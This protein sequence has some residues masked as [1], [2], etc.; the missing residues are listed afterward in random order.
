MP[1]DL[2]NRIDFPKYQRWVDRMAGGDCTLKIFNAAGKP[3]RGRR[4]PA[5]GELARRLLEAPER[6]RAGVHRLEFE[7]GQMLLYRPLHMGNAGFAGWA[8]II[9][10]ERAAPAAPLDLDR[11]G[12]ALDDVV[13]GVVGEAASNYELDRMAEE[14]AECYEDLSLVFGMEARVTAHAWDDQNVLRALLQSTAEH[15]RADVAAFVRPA[16]G[17]CV[18]ATSLS[19]EMQNL[20]LVLIEMRG[21]LFRFVQAAKETV[22]VNEANDPHRPDI[23][24][25]M[26]YRVLASP[27]K[28]EHS[29]EGIVVLLNHVHKRPFSNSDRRLLEVLANQLSNLGE[30]T[31]SLRKKDAIQTTF[32]KYVDPRIVRNLIEDSHFATVGE[33]RPMSVLFS[34][35]EGFTGLCEQI[36]PD[37]AVKFLNGYFNQV[38]GPIIAKQGIIDKYMGD[39]VMAFWGPPFTD[40]ADHARLACEAA[41]EQLACLRE[42]RRTVPDIIGV[43]NKVLPRV[44]MRTGIS[45]GD[46]TVGNVGSDRMKGYT[47]IG[48]TVNLAA[49]LETA[50]KQYGVHVLISEETR[51]HASTAI[52]TRELD[53]VRVVGKSQPV[54]VFELIGMAGGIS[55]SS[56][57]MRDAFE[58]ALDR[59]RSRDLAQARSIWKECA[60]MAP[61][62]RPTRM[63]LERCE[64]LFAQSFPESWDGVWTLSVK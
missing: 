19:K 26:P 36:T 34:D 2:L 9:V 13:A 41:L 39:A 18:Y 44:K 47:V 51:V 62:D 61:D 10:G 12:E 31:A 11:M 23:F 7:G 33:R 52:E 58:A 25:D 46:V 8:A 6:D 4:N 22:V 32:G 64:V 37:A 1:D 56:R 28:V 50:C 14:L 20:D 45:T 16:D 60:R 49:R 53:R 17:L 27:V 55:S 38:S 43:S 40:A 35:L 57:E 15:M 54:S 63:F 59:Y 42:F 5:D 21:R 24:T 30:M 29:V 3:L 48:D